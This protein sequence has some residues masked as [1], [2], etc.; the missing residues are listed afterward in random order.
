MGRQLGNAGSGSLCLDALTNGV[1]SLQERPHLREVGAGVPHPDL[2]SVGQSDRL[3][4]YVCFLR[5][6]RD[7]FHGNGRQGRHTRALGHRLSPRFRLGGSASPD[8]RR[9]GRSSFGR[10]LTLDVGLAGW[11][12]RR[13]RRGRGR[14][15]AVDRSVHCV[16]V[17]GDEGTNALRIRA[18]VGKDSLLLLRGEGTQALDD[19]T[20]LLRQRLGFR[21]G[22]GLGR[23]CGFRRRRPL[24]LG[25]RSRYGSGDRSRYRRHS[26]VRRNSRT[27]V[28]DPTA[29]PREHPS[30]VSVF[31]PSPLLLDPVT[32]RTRLDEGPVRSLDP[33]LSLHQVVVVQPIGG[34]GG[35]CYLLRYRHVGSPTTRSK[36]L[37][38]GGTL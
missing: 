20:L 19:V 2:A 36:F 37:P 22:L 16:G 6:A 31:C 24:C 21:R 32:G 12:G 33:C 18:E 10:T 30:G 4:R 7:A 15:S 25:E 17:A 13:R 11:F 23:G 35:S 8:C 28:L 3:V 9:L 38:A 5:G 26:R 29:Q 1:A 14:N 27:H 34:S